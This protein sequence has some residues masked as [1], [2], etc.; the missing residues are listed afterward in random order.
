MMH[1]RRN[2][3]RLRLGCSVVKLVCGFRD[4]VHQSSFPES[5]RIVLGF[6]ICKVYPTDVGYLVCSDAISSLSGVVTEIGHQ[7]TIWQSPG[8]EIVSS[9]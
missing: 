7:E 8:L 4:I 2:Y 1:I 6:G 9:R 3:R 5:G